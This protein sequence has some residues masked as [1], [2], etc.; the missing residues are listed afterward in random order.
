MPVIPVVPAPAIIFGTIVR[1]FGKAG[2][3]SEDNA[4]TLEELGFK[5]RFRPDL[6][7]S[8]VFRRLVR[9]GH[10]KEAGDGRFYMVQAYYD[11]RMRI[12]KRIPLILLAVAIVCVICGLLFAR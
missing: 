3:F 4:K 11:E 12:R 2:A 7:K 8:P 6:S 1:R 5:T 9:K 10:V